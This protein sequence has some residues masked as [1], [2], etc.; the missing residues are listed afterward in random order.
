VAAIIALGV[1]TVSARP[2]DEEHTYGHTKAEFFASGA[3]GGLILVAAGS[4]IVT[5]GQRLINPQPLEAVG[6]VELSLV[7]SL[8]NLAT[9]QIYCGRAGVT[10][11]LPKGRCQPLMTDVDV[12]GVLV[13]I[14]AVTLTGWERWD[15]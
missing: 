13:G 11:Q 15:Q 1:L 6:L 2:P 7:A 4:I 8:I 9:A 10:T 14:G 3:E 12:G 5:A